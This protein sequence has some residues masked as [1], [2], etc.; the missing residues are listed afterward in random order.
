VGLKIIYTTIGRDDAREF[1]R[2]LVDGG[3]AA[4]VNIVDIHSVYRWEGSIYSEDESLLI[5]KVSEE[6]F[7]KTYKYILENHPYELPELLVISPDKVFEK[8]EDWVINSCT[9]E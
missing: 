3:L 9:Y 1:A 8:Y 4:C 5:I 2:K 6:V 7:N